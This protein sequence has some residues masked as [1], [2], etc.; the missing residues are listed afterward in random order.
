MNE[1]ELRRS[2]MLNMDMLISDELLGVVS[3]E[4]GVLSPQSSDQAHRAGM[5]VA[6]EGNEMN[7]DEL[8]RSGMLVVSVG[9]VR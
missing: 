6:I 9:A 3:R 5:L 7:Q 4:S 1:D 2:G 8:R